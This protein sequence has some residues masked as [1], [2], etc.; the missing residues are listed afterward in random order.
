MKTKH[1]TYCLLCAMLVLKSCKDDE[2]PKAPIAEVPA[3]GIRFSKVPGV[4]ANMQACYYS[5]LVDSGFIGYITYIKGWAHAQLKTTNGATL[6]PDTV[7]T[8]GVALRASKGL[9]QFNPGDT[10]GID[11][12]SAVIWEV[13]KTL[14]N[15]YILENI[16]S[17][18]PEI[19]DLDVNDTLFLS[20]S[21]NLSIDLNN[22][23]TSLGSQTDSTVFF[24]KSNAGTILKR[25][26]GN[27]TVEISPTELMMLGTGEAYIQAESFRVIIKNYNGYKVAFINKGVFNK[28]VWF[29]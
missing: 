18:V 22:P 7:E 14:H 16:N 26:P 1:L 25:L 24:I 17:K 19:G 5:E 27:A 20:E 3:P 6:V 11:Y 8:E 28:K 15:P 29:F 23:V 21:L 12:G 4:N 9:F 2:K 13:S 10:H